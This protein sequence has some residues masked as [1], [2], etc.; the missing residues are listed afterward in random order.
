MA[1][2][3]ECNLKFNLQLRRQA[4]EEF[5]GL[6]FSFDGLETG[7]SASEACHRSW[8]LC[9]RSLT[10]LSMALKQEAFD[11]LDFGGRAS[12]AWHRIPPKL[13]I[14]FLRSLASKLEASEACH[15]NQNEAGKN[16]KKN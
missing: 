7:G 1:L 5:D 8:R 4:S 11:G 15:Q 13:G 16:L 12:E 2:K 3:Q 10:S 9:L 6:D 14:E